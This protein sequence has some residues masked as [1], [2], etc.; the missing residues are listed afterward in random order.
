[1]DRERSHAMFT[2]LPP[3]RSEQDSSAF[4]L[5][6]LGSL[7]MLGVPVDW[8]SFHHGTKRQRVVLPSYPFE[9]QRYWVPPCHRAGKE[10]Y[11]R[12]WN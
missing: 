8:S 12:P 5:Q 7:W 10:E 1:M 9:R 11:R 6:T 3:A 2:S 4:V